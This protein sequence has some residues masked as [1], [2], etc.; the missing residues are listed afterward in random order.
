MARRATVKTK[1][2]EISTPHFLN[3]FYRIQEIKE[4]RLNAT[5]DRRPSTP[6]ELLI[7][8]HTVAHAIQGTVVHA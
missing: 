3:P 1:L 7:S 8:V 2:N 6:S 5:G 4:N